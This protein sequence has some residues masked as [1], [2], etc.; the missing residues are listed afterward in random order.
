MTAQLKKHEPAPD[1]TLADP[2]FIRCPFP[3]YQWML[4]ER[5][6]WRDPSSGFVVVTRYNDVRG[7]LMDPTTWSSRTSQIFNRTSSVSDQVQGL[8]E[9]GGWLPL[10]TLVT[11]DAPEHRRYRSLVERALMPARIKTVQHV[12][13]SAVDRLTTDMLQHGRVEFMESFAIPL[14]MTMLSSQI[15][16][17][18]AGDIQ[19][20]RHWT[21]LMMEAIDPSLEPQRELE[22]TREVLLFQQYVARAIER[23]R[24][25]PDQTILSDLV[26]AELDGE[27]LSVREIIAI[28]TQFFGAGHDTTT[29][30]LGSIVRYLAEH[31]QDHKMLRSHPDKISNFVEEILRLEAPIQRLFR[32]ATKDTEVAGMQVHAGELAIIQYGGANRDERR[33]ACPAAMDADRK[34]ANAHL[35]FGAGVHFC[36]GN[37]LARAELRTAAAA[38]VARC[39]EIRLVDGDKSFSYHMQFISRSLSRLDIEV[40]PA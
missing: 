36:V 26:H 10:D 31:P 4:E 8:Y 15:A 19:L 22:I 5:P 37:Q 18:A 34:D 39:A 32:R 27:H 35:T 24:A 38:I 1:F 16:G 17:A 30:A 7:I 9:A 40:T 14:T 11:N 33:F 28:A 13:D 20:I 12:I 23:L 21:E 3:D 29:S 2:D 25:R 6:A